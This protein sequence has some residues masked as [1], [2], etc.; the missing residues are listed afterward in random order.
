MWN[1]HEISIKSKFTQYFSRFKK[2]VFERLSPFVYV[3]FTCVKIGDNLFF[4]RGFFVILVVIY[5]C[6][7][8]ISIMLAWT[9]F[10]IQPN[11][12]EILR[13]QWKITD[14]HSDHEWFR[15]QFIRSSTSSRQQQW[16]SLSAA[17]A[18][19]GKG[20][21]STCSD[22]GQLQVISDT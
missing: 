18:A 6:L 15:W 13:G 22:I 7:R 19:K 2:A 12:M 14:I 11:I 1:A 17:A 21:R 3:V 10:G 8:T 20:Y 4:R 5:H 9:L 16:D